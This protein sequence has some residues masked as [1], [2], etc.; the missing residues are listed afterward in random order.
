MSDAHLD[1]QHRPE[2]RHRVA[3]EEIRRAPHRGERDEAREVRRASN[4]RP[5]ER[6]LDLEQPRLA[7]DAARVA[8]EAAVA[9]DHAVA[10]HDDRERIAAGRGARGARGSG[11]AG[12]RGELGVGD[13]LAVR[14]A[15][16]LDPH[17]PLEVRALGRERQLEASPLA[18][19]ILLDLAFAFGERCRGGILLPLARDGGR[20]AAALEVEA[21][22]G[23]A[24]GGGEQRAERA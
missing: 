19:E 4:E 23:A 13:R 21:G 14:D 2:V 17:A 11:R 22:E 9:A 18:F 7:L 12:A 10:R 1:Q 20:V 3:H 8:G 16:D 5:G 15:R 6:A 24:G